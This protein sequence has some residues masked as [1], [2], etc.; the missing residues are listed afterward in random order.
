MSDSVS[1]EVYHYRIDDK[2]NV[3]YVA[4]IKE[5]EIDVINAAVIVDE[6][7]DF[8]SAN[9]DNSNK[10]FQELQTAATGNNDIKVLF[11]CKLVLANIYIY[12]YI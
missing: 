11:H 6:V 9:E 3:Q 4:N 10:V 1:I 5:D 2:E 12:I 8:I 7:Q